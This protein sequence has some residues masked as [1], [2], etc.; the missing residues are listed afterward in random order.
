MSENVCSSSLTAW[1]GLVHC[2][3]SGYSDLQI[4]VLIT[5]IH[6]EK[7]TGDSPAL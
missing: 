1:S 2:L 3:G 4:G 6:Q 5:A 7:I